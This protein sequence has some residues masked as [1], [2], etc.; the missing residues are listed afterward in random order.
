MSTNQKPWYKDAASLMTLAVATTAVVFATYCF[1]TGRKNDKIKA[2]Q[3][4]AAHVRDSLRTTYLVK[5]RPDTML[6]IGKDKEDRF[7][8]GH[9]ATWERLELATQDGIPVSYIV[10]K[11]ADNMT[12]VRTAQRGDKLLV[13]TSQ[14]ADSAYHFQILRNLTAEKMMQEFANQ[15]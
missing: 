14:T 4:A 3:E 11:D 9:L 7:F 6:V 1:V 15:K 5:D 13:N 12:A 2:Q 8:H 10:D